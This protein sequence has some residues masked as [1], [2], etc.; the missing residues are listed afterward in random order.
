[1]RPG[2]DSVSETLFDRLGDTPILVQL[3]DHFYAKDGNA[4]RCLWGRVRLHKAKDVVGFDPKNSANW[5]L[6]VGS[7]PDTVMVMGCRIHY[8]QLC[9]DA[10]LGT[11]ILKLL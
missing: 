4:Y 7:S 11:H 2:G 10:P 3:D 6:E 8:A 9:P 5:F 1:M